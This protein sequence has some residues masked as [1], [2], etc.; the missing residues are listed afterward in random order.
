ML[1]YIRMSPRPE[2]VVVI[3]KRPG[4]LS[5]RLHGRGAVA[6]LIIQLHLTLVIDYYEPGSNGTICFDGYV[7]VLITWTKVH[8]RSDQNTA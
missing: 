1:A 2:V 5:L 8:P 4:G 6:E 3:I 7:L